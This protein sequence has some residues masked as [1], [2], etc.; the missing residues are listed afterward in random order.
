MRGKVRCDAA[1]RA[2]SICGVTLDLAER[3]QP[4]EDLGDAHRRKDVFLAM[5]AHELRHPLAPISSAAQLR[6]HLNPADQRL[7]RA[8]DII[9]RQV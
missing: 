9:V 1:G 8:T 3:I 4:E 2:A 7:T 5:L 6:A